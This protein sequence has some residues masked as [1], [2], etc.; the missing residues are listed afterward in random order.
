MRTLSFLLCYSSSLLTLSGATIFEEVP[1]ATTITAGSAL[2][3]SFLVNEAA[4]GGNDNNATDF[5][6]DYAGGTALYSAGQAVSLVGL[7]W[8]SSAS[9]T[10]ATSATVTFT[11]YGPDNT[12]GTG[13]DVVVGTVTDTLNFGDAGVYVWVFD[14][15]VNFS[16]QGDG[17][18]IRIT[19]DGNIRRKT[20]S[21]GSQGAVKLSIAGTPVPSTVYRAESS[22]DW[23]Q[24]SWNS[25]AGNLSGDIP[26]GETVVVG[27][28]R[29]VVYNGV[30]ASETVSR[31]ILGNNST[32]Q[33]LGQGRLQ[34]LSG[35]LSI[36]GDLFVGVENTLN[37]A[38]LTI[39]GSA[40]VSVGG[41]AEF[42]T[43]AHSC[44]GS[45]MIEGNGQFSVGGNL[46]MGGF[47]EGGALLKV[48]LPGDLP[49]VTVT[50]QLELD[51]CIL[52]LSFSDS[53]AHVPGTTFTLA[54]YGSRHGQFMNFREGDAFNAG[55]NRFRIQYDVDGNTI[56]LTALENFTTTN[57]NP[58][59]IIYILV[60][61]QGYA[62]NPLNPFS[63]NNHGGKDWSTVFPMPRLESLA[64]NGVRFTNG[65]VTG[66][67][68]HPSRAGL[69]TG[70]Y[71][72]RFGADN[73]L[74][75]ENVFGISPAAR[76]I[77]RR[78]Q[79][80]G[81][82]TY[83]VGK[84]HL[85]ESVENHPNT[86]G[87]DRW[88]GMWLGSR[89]YYSVIGDGQEELRVFQEDMEPD[90]VAENQ[91]QNNY[92]TD[93]IG[94]R[95]VA[96]IDEHLSGHAG[97]PFYLYLSFTSPHGP[98]DIKGSD[99]RFTELLDTYG[100]DLSDYA[101]MPN[102]IGGASAAET[103]AKRYSLAA[104]CLA[105]DE[106]IGKVLDK[107]TAEGELDNTII[108]YQS[109]N[110]GTG[111]TSNYSI[112]APLTGTKGGSCQEGSF[113][114]PTVVQWP[115]QFT[116]GQVL[117]TPVT[118]L[119]IAASFVNAPGAPAAARNGLDGLDLFDHIKNGTALPANRVLT[120]RGG[121]SN[122][123]G[124]AIRMGPYKLLFTDISQSTTLYDFSGAAEGVVD[125]EYSEFG[126]INVINDPAIE[127]HLLQRFKAWE[128]RTIA[129]NYLG[130]RSVPDEDLDYFPL[131]GA[132][133]LSTRATETR[134]LSFRLRTPLPFS[135]DWE[136]HFYVRATEAS[137]GSNAR[138]V[139]AFGD[140]SHP[141]ATSYNNPNEASQI[142]AIRGNR[143]N[144]I[145]CVIDYDNSRLQI[146]DGRA[147]TSNA[148]ALPPAELPRAFAKATVRYD[149]ATAQLTF[150][151]G[152]T[153]VSHTLTGN[154]S[155]WL[156]A[157][158]GCAAME[159]E[160]TALR[161][162]DQSTV[163]IEL[164]D[165]D[166]VLVDVIYDNDPLFSL[167][168]QRSMDLGNGF[169]DDDDL[170]VESLGGGHYRLTGSRNGAASTFFR[171]R[172]SERSGN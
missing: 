150:S 99:P 147:G 11:D 96:F 149:E 141:N 30:P 13:D 111:S 113:R 55:P 27:D 6:R 12:F 89:A 158:V 20:T 64:S 172:Q 31:V 36:S 71:Q 126:T 3:T 24:I 94:D 82:R 15:P 144:L 130:E 157:A 69:I 54:T 122:S 5:I 83:G 46:A 73:N 108:V 43:S 22:G 164:V 133:R 92:L 58:P 48:E 61:D 84:W 136:R 143:G 161:T 131:I 132:Y 90:Y 59:N 118:S 120:F 91:A 16:A 129:P 45:L 29:T 116:G 75:T 33:N 114:V 88:Y 104:M 81:Y 105:H 17:L 151:L 49:A 115:A 148:V 102:G 52:D 14:S 38:F 53:Y 26:D 165:A 142:A 117:D 25:E 4:T 51:R 2:G 66:G 8:A 57:P 65:Y 56:Q 159:G 106:N 137:N 87:F 39:G 35:D 135:A 128:A 67:V 101:G 21:G 93:R 77:P 124:S 98:I 162:S 134:F 74:P 70:I 119:D 95:A 50:G 32:P 97:Q 156:Y 154:Y 9:G 123:A 10:T 60:D 145:Q 63:V 34:V 62:D 127:A 85:G 146:I 109:D 107:L 23:D 18:R 80:L 112:N 47:D 160:I 153:S 7:A 169:N 167:I 37:D 152:G 125:S 163:S 168:G 76:T 103:Q 78:L 171:L 140:D 44:D 79:S 138:M 100:L 110:G 86:R 68:C 1:G 42:G 19:S 166:G 40:S 121:G 72:Q 170:L 28:D 139:Y 41:D 155:D